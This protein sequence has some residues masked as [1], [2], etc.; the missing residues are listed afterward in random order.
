MLGETTVTPGNITSD[1][2]LVTYT[3]LADECRT[4]GAEKP[5]AA[6]NEGHMMGK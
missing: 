5:V 4:A 3:K 2:T 6:R 1:T